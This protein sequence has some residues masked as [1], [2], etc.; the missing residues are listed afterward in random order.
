MNW[1]K[2]Y[3]L[4]L[5]LGLLLGACAK[6]PQKEEVS[7]QDV[8]SKNPVYYFNNG[9][10]SLMIEVKKT[11]QKAV[12]FSHFMTE[13][14]LAL[15]LGDKIVVGTEEGQVYPDFKEAYNKIPKKL[16]GHHAL[17][18]KEEFLLSG[19]DFVSGWDEAIRAESTGTPKELVEKG[20]YPFTA[21]SIRDFQTLDTVYEDFYT[22]G[23]IFGVEKKA[24]KV[25]EGMKNKLAQAEKF[26]VKKSDVEKKKVLIFSSIENGIYVSGGLTTDLINRAG[27]KNIYEELGADHEMVSFESL[28]HRNPDIIL[29]AHLAGGM[30]FEEKKKVLKS[31]PALQNL[32]AIKND[33]IHSI[34]LED[35]SPGVRNIDFII[36]LNGLMYG[37]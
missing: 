10:D 3:V 30:D 27:G 26:F 9:S 7:Y 20:I 25:V 21:K 19:V 13:M 11:P 12:L 32:P 37:R 24:E 33:N 22:L 31:H 2:I 34:A 5:A 29:I 14:L 1:C 15:D 17:Y 8:E 18:T 28:V 6:S 36:K 35:I 23:K 4:G 16:A